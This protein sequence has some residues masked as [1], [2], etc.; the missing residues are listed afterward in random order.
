MLK[1]AVEGR[2]ADGRA[3]SAR[4][5]GQAPRR[6]G[7][8]LGYTVRK[9]WTTLWGNLEQVRVSRL[10]GGQEIGLLERYE[11]H[12]LDEVLFALTVGGLS[13]RHVVGWVRRF[14]GGRL[15]PASIA[16]VLQQAQQQVAQRRSAP[17]PPGKYRAV[18]VDGMYLRYR[19]SVSQAAR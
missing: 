10:R 15:S 5:R 18:V 1:R 7:V 6:E 4:G 11:R 8:S 16:A 14:L 12:G 13:Q 3:G 19:R 17:I 9:C 2:I